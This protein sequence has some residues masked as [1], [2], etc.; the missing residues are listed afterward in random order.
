MEDALKLC[1]WKENDTEGNQFAG[2]LHKVVSY[3][4]KVF[5]NGM[6]M[7]KFHRLANLMQL[8]QY[9]TIYVGTV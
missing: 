6:K 3:K 2:Q 5:R 4:T 7:Y 1:T 8:S 9:Q